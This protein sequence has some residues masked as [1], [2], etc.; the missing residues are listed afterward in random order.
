MGM[1]GQQIEAHKMIL[2]VSSPFC[3]RKN[4]HIQ[5]ILGEANIYQEVLGSFLVI[6]V[7]NFTGLNSTLPHFANFRSVVW[8]GA[9]CFPVWCASLSFNSSM[10]GF[11]S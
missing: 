2:A 9:A 11:E 4:I 1:D 3:G 6:G 5:W 10:Q 7:L 8:G